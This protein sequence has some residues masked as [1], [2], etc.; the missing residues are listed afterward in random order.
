M[1]AGLAV[2]I[3]LIVFF[4][5]TGPASA[6][7]TIIVG[8]TAS[9]TGCDLIAHNED[10]DTFDC[11]IV[12]AVPAATHAPG[13]VYEL[14]YGGTAPLP[15]QTQGY[16]ATAVFDKSLIPGD[17][18]GVINDSQVSIFNNYASS[19]F[20]WGKKRGV[21]WTEFTDLAAMRATTARDAIQIIGDL[22]QAHGLGMDDGTMFGVADPDEGWWIEIAGHQWVAQRVPDS[23]AEMRANCFRIGVVDFN[24]PADFA[25]SPNVVACARR[26]GWYRPADGPFNWA[27]AYGWPGNQRWKGNTIRQKMVGR[28][29]AADLAQGPITK[30]Q[31]MTI[32]RGHFE[33]SRYYNLRCHPYTVCNNWTIASSV[34]EL[35]G[36]LPAGIGGV[37]WTSLSVP[38]S[39]GYVPWYEG[40]TQVPVEYTMGSR[41]PVPGSAY[42][43]CRRLAH[44]VG[45][46]YKARHPAVASAW[47]TFEQGEFDQQTAVEA[48][49]L[50]EYENVSPAAAW[51]YL[52][53]YTGVQAHQAYLQTELLKH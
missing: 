10:D 50:D 8:K 22:A 28:Y 11:Q 18:T 21:I 46:S 20:P 38:C 15:D 33:G 37:L 35:R 17:T 26:H 44:W 41:V 53:T 42:W 13:S 1:P 51:E 31:L 24:D 47:Q 3:S 16:I 39:N 30:Q 27:K 29:L 5:L 45:T 6:C 25:W 9:A 19:K 34:A 48:T 40:I 4:A 23:A 36:S 32:L 43:A 49:A 12:R 52:T 14:L 7:T 2:L